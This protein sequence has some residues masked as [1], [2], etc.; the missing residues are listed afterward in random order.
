[1]EGLMMGTQMLISSLIEN[2]DRNHGTTEIVTRTVEGPIHR[3]TYHD[4]HRRSRQLANAL[5][6]L[7][8]KNGDRCATLAWNTHRHFE[9]YYGVSGMGA[10]CHTVNPRL[11]PPQIVFIMNHA[12]DHC[13]FVDLTFVPL[14][15]ELAGQL[16]HTEAIIIMTDEANMPKT[17]LPNVHCYEALING[18]SDDFD[19]PEFDE[20]TASSL[21]Y[22]SGTTGDPKGVLFSHRSS[23]IHTYRGAMA[24]CFGLSARDTVL[25]VVPMFHVL[26]WGLPY[27]AAMVGCKLVLPGPGLDGPSLQELIEIEKINFSAG[28][29]TIWL[30][31]LQHLEQTGKKIEAMKRVVIG[32]SATPRSMIKDFKEKHGAEVLHAWGMTE[33]SPIGTVN[34]PKHG[35]GDE[36]AEEQYDRLIKQGREVYGAKMKIVDDDDRT[37]PNDG[38]AFGTLKVRGPS[39]CSGYYNE[40]PSEAHDQNGWFSTGDVATIDPDGYMQI[41]DRSKDVIKSGGE[42]ISSIELENIAVGHPDVAEAASIAVHHPKWDE[43]PLLLVIRRE[44]ANLTRETMLQYFEGKVAKW[45]IPDDVAFVEE[46]PHTATGKLLKIK[47]RED[48]KDYVLPS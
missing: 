19:W 33:M 5:G 24:D 28:V 23:I 35:M 48:Y 45:W 3:Y 17:S 15:E 14:L 22:T 2:A 9:I 40:G 41:T 31:L 25:P 11:F 20:N 34:A 37:L 6:S 38:K 32:G 42:W 10:I 13:I 7:G 12:A 29:P 18:H 26:A 43:R 27:V 30:G 46:L 8:I 44:G 4:A 1:M 36:P 16:E 39:V 21:C 47:I